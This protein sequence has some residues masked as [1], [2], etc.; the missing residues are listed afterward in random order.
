MKIWIL[1]H[2]ASSPDRAAGTR[3]YEF[4]RVFAE[5]GHE[6]TIFA[7][8]FCHFTRAE[9]RMSGEGCGSSGSM[10]S[11]LYGSERPLHG[12]WHPS[13]TEYD[14]LCRRRVADPVPVLTTRRHRRI[15]CAFGR[16]RRRLSDWP[17]PACTLR[18][19]GPRFVAADPHRYGSV[20]GRERGRAGAA[21]MERFLYAGPVWSSP[22][23]RGQ[24]ITSK[25][26]ASLGENGL[27]PERDRRGP[28]SHPVSREGIALMSRIQEWHRA[29]CPWRV[30]W[31]RTGTLMAWT[32]W[33]EPRMNCSRGARAGSPSCSWGR[34]RRRSDASDWRA[35]TDSRM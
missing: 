19:R 1:N 30:M 12:Q 33:S 13:S 34:D 11:V 8:S 26:R 9:E 29:G 24:T 14:E 28:P 32:C 27:C 31:G 25:D 6:V 2:Y 35:N 22:C 20:A 5:Q 3:H 21:S 16:C 10:V 23:C 7:S 18:L 17:K 4:G 15:F